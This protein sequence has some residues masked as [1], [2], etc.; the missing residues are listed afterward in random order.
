MGE[1]YF[2]QHRAGATTDL[3]INHYSLELSL[4][5]EAERGLHVRTYLWGHCQLAHRFA[6]LLNRGRIVRKK[7]HASDGLRRRGRCCIC[8]THADQPLSCRDSGAARGPEP[9]KRCLT[10]SLIS[11]RM[12]H[13][14]FKVGVLVPDCAAWFSTATDRFS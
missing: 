9:A 10:L 1:T 2:F 12:R 11:P 5:Q 6:D 3:E 4:G 7:Q 14:L 8:V 13:L